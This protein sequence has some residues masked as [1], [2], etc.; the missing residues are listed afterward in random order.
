MG[1]APVTQRRAEGIRQVEMNR[2]GKGFRLR[3][4]QQRDDRGHGLGFRM[5][6]NYTEPVGEGKEIHDRARH[7]VEVMLHVENQQ[8]RQA[9]RGRRVNVRFP[10]PGAIL[11][12]RHRNEV[13]Y[14]LSGSREIVPFEVIRSHDRSGRGRRV[15]QDAPAVRRHAALRLPDR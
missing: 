7:A 1:F 12:E 6:A 8:G 15:K 10:F 4:E 14:G 3:S 13:G 9:R 5:S 11:K 2:S